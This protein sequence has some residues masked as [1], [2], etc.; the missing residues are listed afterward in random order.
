MDCMEWFNET[1]LPSK[2]HIFNRSIR[3][4]HARGLDPIHAWITYPDMH[5][6]FEKSMRGG[7]SNICYRHAT[8]NHPSMDTYDENDLSRC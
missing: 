4:L 1:S 3:M 6:M 7:I 8:S 5:L 2:E